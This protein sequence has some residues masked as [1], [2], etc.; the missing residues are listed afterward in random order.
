MSRLWL[1]GDMQM[2]LLSQAVEQSAASIIITDTD[3]VIEF[4]NAAFTA[5]TGYTREEALGRKTSMLSAGQTPSEVYRDM[6]KTIKA[7]GSWRGEMLNRRK[8]GEV[9][10]DGVVINPVLDEHGA[11][12]GYVALQE[13]ITA[14]KQAEIE[15]RAI[16]QTSHDGYWMVSAQDARFIEVNTAAARM[17]GYAP[18][19]MLKMRIPDVEAA[20]SPEFIANNIRAIMSSPTRSARFETRHRHR[21]GHVLDVEVSTQYI[22]VRGGILVAFIR[23]ISERKAAQENMLLSKHIL[24]SISEGVA[25]TDSQ[26]RFVYVNPAFTR[27]TGYA[28]EDVLGRSPK[29]LSSGL[30]EKT[31]YGRMWGSID[32][33]G[34]WE[35]EII[36]RRKSG[37]SYNE[38]LSIS[39]LKDERGEV[40]R[41]VSVF[42]DISER[43]AVERHIVHLAQHD[44]LT[45]L[46]NRMLLLDRLSQAIALA[47]RDNRRV[48]VLFFDLDRFKNIND[49]LGHLIGDKF[50]KE[51]AARISGASRA[52]DT[53]SRLGGDEFVVMLTDI[54]S[55][56]DVSMIAEKMLASVAG[57][58]HIDGNDIEIT[59]SIGISLFPD[60][61]GDA[62]VLLKCADTAMY[63]AKQ[64]GRNNFQFFTGEMN[65]RA[66]ER[67]A[68]ES[69]LR[70]AIRRKEFLLY[71]QPQVD[72][73]SGRLI[74]AEALLRWNSPSG[75]VGPSQF[76][77]VAEETGLILQ[78]GDWALRE[79]CRQ[80][81]AWR[82]EGLPEMP[83]SV[84]LSA[85]QFRQK[86]LVKQIKDALDEFGLE[87]SALEL[88]ITE[89][90]VMEDPESAIHMLLE[91]QAMG[92][93]LALD[94]F[95]T[96]Y[97]SL[98]YLKRLPIG[99]L[100]IDQTFVRHMTEDVDD[101]MIVSAI[102][103]LARNLDLRHIAEGVETQEQV[104]LLAL[105]GCDEMQGYFYGRPMPAS[106][107]AAYC[108]RK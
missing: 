35:G 84:N 105:Y 19:E 22:E 24:N 101:A 26:Q 63:H 102:I 11:I 43:K 58:C 40:D 31:F 54:G 94:D 38:W 104:D 6:W 2:R 95:G 74:G 5:I 49:T 65:R 27:I 21:D 51:V 97:S 15:Y 29:L 8:N 96:G 91:I 46:P 16:L 103:N 56:E 85:V 20:Q 44:F 7:G 37:E 73:A 9:Y 10:W 90:A 108:A 80:I 69:K 93:K 36:D 79:A 55:V 89:S 23:D 92:V 64:N 66:L 53:I 59:T 13:D 100:K 60:D 33:E 17:L 99:K 50:L 48:A 77:E 70:Q 98:I 41:Y 87:P 78:I 82:K 14:R 76:I 75:L 71:Y 57:V 32:E 39:T 25:V 3:G 52:S 47:R 28:E 106:E 81:A 45:G 12:T 18:E 88:E 42:S 72:R 62:E 61:G 83:V 1:Q 68:M 86:S 34:R 30:M 107:F 4:V 67:M